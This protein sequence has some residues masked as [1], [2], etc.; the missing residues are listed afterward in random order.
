MSEEAVIAEAQTATVWQ[1]ELD[2][3]R[4]THGG[5][6]RAQDVVEFASDPETALHEHFEWDDTEAGRLYREQQARQLIAVYVKSIPAHNEPIRAYVSLY[7]DRKRPGGGYRTIED[8]MSNEE[9]Q[10]QLL[11][12]AIGEYKH[13]EQKYR[14]LKALAPV[15]KAVNSLEKKQAK[16]AAKDAA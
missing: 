3:V 2:L 6:L 16:K 12:Q 5:L 14:S 8:V 15:F 1:E 13:L 7:V 10:A 4:E 9:L 11:A